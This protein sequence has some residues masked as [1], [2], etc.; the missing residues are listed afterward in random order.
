MKE[1]NEALDS[2]ESPVI[3]L[4]ETGAASTTQ[5]FQEDVEAKTLRECSALAVTL[6]RTIEYYA[7]TMGSEIT[8]TS[9]DADSVSVENGTHKC[10]HCN[11]VVHTKQ[12]LL[13][14]LEQLDLPP[15]PLDMVVSVICVHVPPSSRKK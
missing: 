4:W 9:S 1:V 10:L 12:S 15:P 2:G 6:R 3:S 13:R 11:T 5:I 7:A 14:R 8:S